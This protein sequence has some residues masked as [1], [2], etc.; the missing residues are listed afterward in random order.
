MPIGVAE[1]HKATVLKTV[2]RQDWASIADELVTA[3]EI[4]DAIDAVRGEIKTPLKTLK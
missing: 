4:V 1:E 2:W 3:D